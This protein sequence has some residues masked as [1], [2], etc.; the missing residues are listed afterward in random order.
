MGNTLNAKDGLRFGCPGCG[1]GL[2]YDIKRK[3]MYCD[4]CGQTYILSDIEDPSAKAGDGMME[5]TECRCPQ[6]G[7]AVHTSQTAI[8]SFCTYCGADV[9][10]S[11]RMIRIRR[12]DRIVPFS[13]TRE[14]CEKIYRDKVKAA[15]FAPEDFAAQETI[16]HFRPVYI[17]FWE[18]KG[19]VQG[20][21]AGEAVHR[22]SDRKYDYT[23]E[24]AFDVSGSVDVSGVIYDA[25]LS[26]E[27]ETAQHLQFST[28]QAVSFHPAYLCGFY[29][30]APDTQP[31]LYEGG[32]EGFALRQWQGEF[33]KQ[34]GLERARTSLPKGFS[35]EVEMLLM[36][37][38]LLAKR[39]GDR[40]VYTAVN[41]NSGA[42]VCDTPVSNRKFGILAAEFTAVFLAALLVLHFLFI[43]RPRPLAG[44]CAVIAAVAQWVI[45]NA[46]REIEMRQ[47]K[48]NDLSWQMTHGQRSAAGKAWKPRRIRW[49]AGWYEPLIGT[50]AAVGI[51]MFIS[52]LHSSGANEFVAGLV[53]DHGWLPTVL[54]CCAIGVFLLSRYKLQQSLDGLLFLL[55]LGMIGVLLIAQFS[56]VADLSYYLF[57]IVLMALTVLSMLRLN[58]AHNLFV[59]RPVPFFG[60]EG[61]A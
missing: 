21:S 37:V 28:R 57:C 43:L 41:G 44:L 53:S 51:G 39:D 31:T 17:P 10:L 36:P 35:T 45:A 23:D 7:A 13:I 9:I 6:C 14:Q 34:C 61:D 24:Y 58:R 1:S 59:S 3:T 12:P 55:R 16:D 33:A 11:Q 8:T 15:R 20:A 47:D 52:G 5:A 32:A 22:Y 46:A 42:I 50:A 30:E 60:K 4:S 40:V 56:I 29:A 2:R 48:S 38:W 49:H 18:Y 27:D 54:L 19:S 25:S 26:F